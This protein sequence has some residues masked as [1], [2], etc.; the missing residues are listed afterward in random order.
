MCARAFFMYIA[1]CLISHQRIASAHGTHAY[2]EVI[3]HRVVDRVPRHCPVSVASASLRLQRVMLIGS[4]KA[5][6]G[7]LTNGDLSASS[8]E[9]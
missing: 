1:H 2:A 4:Q 9:P 8:S 3:Q 7:S 6:P 5:S